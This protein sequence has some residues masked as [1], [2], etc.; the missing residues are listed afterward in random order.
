MWRR[1][2]SGIN[3]SSIFAWAGLGAAGTI[4]ATTTIAAGMAGALWLVAAATVGGGAVAA[5]AAAV[6]AAAAVV[7]VS[8]PRLD[9]PVG[10]GEKWCTRG[11]KLCPPRILTMPGPEKGRRWREWEEEDLK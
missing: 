10:G 2:G 7:A 4:E 8:G 6:G 11:L 9:S 5:G 3:S 1:W